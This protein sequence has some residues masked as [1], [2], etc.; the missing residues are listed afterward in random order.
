MGISAVFKSGP[1]MEYIMFIDFLILNHPCLSEI[2]ST[3]L[4]WIYLLV[5]H[6]GLS[7]LLILEKLAID[8]L[9]CN[10]LSL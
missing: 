4:Q 7:H 6:L 1:L 8:L 10:L 3:W 2:K 5:F 9:I